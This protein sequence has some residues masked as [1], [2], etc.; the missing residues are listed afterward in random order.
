MTQLRY[1][2][3]LFAFAFANNK[4][5]YLAIVLAVAS[6]V[7][8]LAAVICL[9]PL[10]QVA[11]DGRI[12]RDSIVVRALE[13]A[14]R[15]PSGNELL[16]VF[17]T[18]LA[19]RIITQ[20]ASQALSIR[21]SRAVQM[22][23]TTRA[24]SVIVNQVPVRDLEARSVG[25]YISMAGDEAARASNIVMAGISLL[26]ASVLA[27]FYYAAIVAFS[28]PV[29]LFVLVFLVGSFVMLL[30][31]FAASQKLG[32]RQIDQS[33]AATSL[34]IDTMN[35][36]RVIR[37]FSAERYIA[38][39]YTR[40]IAAYTQTLVKIDVISLL[41][42][43]G[44]ALFLI[45]L[46]AGIVAYQPA[47]RYLSL[48]LPFLVTIVVMMLRFFPLVGQSLNLLLRIVADT[49]A[50]KD[51]TELIKSYEPPAA[52]QEPTG[53]TGPSPICTIEI[54]RLAFTHASGRQVLRNAHVSLHA[55]KSYALVGLSG[56]GKSTLL[57]LL[58]RF[59]DPD[60]GSIELN[61]TSHKDYDLAEVRKRIILVSQETAIF[62]DTVLNNIRLGASASREAIIAAASI[63]GIDDV[64]RD[65]PDGY[66]TLL[67]YRGSNLSGGQ[68]QRLGIA[69]AVL[70][71]PDVMLLDESTSAL[72]GETRERVV[73]NLRHVFK[74]RILVFVTHDSYVMSRVDEVL[75]MAI[76]DPDLTIEPEGP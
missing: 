57:D 34:F 24:F 61:G 37:S 69:R 3:S 67:N 60:R 9:L 45:V 26:T 62:N 58:L 47:A 32:F 70:R 1:L 17:L 66:D 64:I 31:A 42:R 16:L 49:R 10:A 54:S 8:E 68:R 23:L 59:H 12:P 74:D 27:L 35:S 55:G 75:D 44:P 2:S 56:S 76:L 25:Y 15:V 36:L 13:W 7:L 20:F 30:R 33:Q 38:D 63:A 41:G 48:E 52:R 18:I 43:L 19:S 29:A 72:D 51:V 4:E 65:L 40:Q 21:M 11:A 5:L 39:F 22:Q 6:N 71:S 14:G 46:L 28:A 73:A 53:Q 50:G